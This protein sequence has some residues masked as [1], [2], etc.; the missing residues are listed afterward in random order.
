MYVGGVPRWTGLWYLVSMTL[1]GG[2]KWNQLHFSLTDDL[3]VGSVVGIVVFFVSWLSD[4]LKKLK[5]ETH[6]RSHWCRFLYQMPISLQ[7]ERSAFFCCKQV[8]LTQLHNRSANSHEQNT[9]F[10][11]SPYALLC[12][13]YFLC[14]CM[15]GLFNNDVSSSGYISLSIIT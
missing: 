14:M 4:G 13:V 7:I 15:C 3:R 8:D 5:I 2:S 9:V 1:F 11:I 6:L 10:W 12:I